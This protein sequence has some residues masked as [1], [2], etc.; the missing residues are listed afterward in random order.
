MSVFVYIFVCMCLYLCLCLRMLAFFHDSVLHSGVCECMRACVRACV[1]A[2][3]CVC[4]RLCA[5]VFV[6]VFV[7]VCV[8]VSLFVCVCVCVIVCIHVRELFSTILV[9]RRFVRVFLLFSLCVPV[10]CVCS[11]VYVG[12][13]GGG[14]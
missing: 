10:L 5:C 7:H 9:H 6:Y 2:C 8:C 4:V 3:V 12:G 11:C 13:V 1:C 14:G